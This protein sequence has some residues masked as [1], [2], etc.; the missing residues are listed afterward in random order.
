M[1]TL[2]E[3]LKQ[4][5]PLI[6]KDTDEEIL[7]LY[8]PQYQNAYDD[9]EHFQQAANETNWNMPAPKAR[10]SPEPTPP[11]PKDQNY[12][13]G[14]WNNLGKGA[15]GTA[16]MVAG[17]GEYLSDVTGAD[18][19]KDYF[20][21]RRTV[22]G[23]IAENIA[24]PVESIEEIDGLFSGFE[25]A[26]GQ[27]AQQ[28]LNLILAGSLVPLAGAIVPG[29]AAGAGLVTKLSH[30]AM[31]AAIGSAPA[32][33]VLNTGESYS[34]LENAG[35]ATV[36]GSV[37][38]AL[39]SIGFGLLLGGPMGKV[40]GKSFLKAL[41]ST[42]DS[43]AV[44]KVLTGIA[45]GIASEG[46][47]EGAQEAVDVAAEKYIKDLGITLTDDDIMGILN[48]AASGAA[49]G[50]LLGGFGNF[51][52]HN[53]D[54]TAKEEVD[55]IEKAIKD[56]LAGLSTDV[57]LDEELVAK[58]EEV[59]K[60]EGL[61]TEGVPNGTKAGLGKLAQSVEEQEQIEV[62]PF[63]STEIVSLI[64]GE[65]SEVGPF[66][67]EEIDPLLSDEAPK[68][69][70]GKEKAA[71]IKG[72]TA[73]VEAPKAEAS[74]VE[75]KAEAKVEAP[76]KEAPAPVVVMTN[77]TS[78][79]SLNAQKAWQRTMGKPA[80]ATLTEDQL[81]AFLD[82]VSHKTLNNKN[83][84][85]RKLLGREEWFKN[86]LAGRKETA[87]Q[88]TSQKIAHLITV[89]S[90]SVITPN[91]TDVAIPEDNKDARKDIIKKYLGK[92]PKVLTVK[93]I[94]ELIKK[95]PSEHLASEY[96]WLHEIMADTPYANWYGNLVVQE[97]L[98][99]EVKGN[100]V[101]DT[102]TKID[103]AP[104][105]TSSKKSAFELMTPEEKVEEEK[106][107]RR[108]IIPAL[109][110]GHFINGYNGA[111]APAS[112]L[113]L[114]RRQ[115]VAETGDLEA[116]AKAGNIPYYAWYMGRIHG[117]LKGKQYADEVIDKNARRAA[118]KDSKAV[119]VVNLGGKLLTKDGSAEATLA[120]DGLYDITIEGKPYG[121]RFQ[122]EKA[123][124]DFLEAYAFRQAEL[125]R[126]RRGKAKY[127]ASKNAVEEDSTEIDPA[128]AAQMSNEEAEGTAQADVDDAFL[129][130]VID[131]ERDEVEEGDTDNLAEGG[132]SV[133]GGALHNSYAYQDGQVR[134]PIQN[135]EKWAKVVGEMRAL[136]E[137]ILGSSINRMFF[138]EAPYI[139]WGTHSARGVTTALPNAGHIAIASISKDGRVVV[140][141]ALHLAERLGLVAPGDINILNSSKHQLIAL[142]EEAKK[143]G[144]LFPSTDVTQKSMAEIRAYGLEAYYF[145]KNRGKNPKTLYGKAKEIFSRI[146]N[147]FKNMRNLLAQND[148]RTY[149]DIFDDFLSGKMAAKPNT[150]ATL[151]YFKK[152]RLDAALLPHEVD[153]IGNTV[154]RTADGQPIVFFRR[155]A[156]EGEIVAV[157]QASAMN[158]SM[159][160][161]DLH[162]IDFSIAPAFMNMKN[163]LMI[164]IS[165][166]NPSP[167]TIME[168]LIERSMG[169]TVSYNILLGVEQDMIK[170]P[171]K[172]WKILTDVLKSAGF[173]G[174]QIN[175]VDFLPHWIS[176][177]ENQFVY[178]RVPE[179]IDVPAGLD[180]NFAEVIP[181]EAVPFT[182]A[183]VAQKGQDT[184][185]GT[186][187]KVA[188]KIADPAWI[189]DHYPAFAPI[190]RVAKEMGNKASEIQNKMLPKLRTF[191]ENYASNPWRFSVVG[192]NKKLQLRINKT[193]NLTRAVAAMD[194]FGLTVLEDKISP[195]AL[196]EDM[197]QSLNEDGVSTE[198]FLYRV[199]VKQIQRLYGDFYGEE[200]DIPVNDIFH[201]ESTFY[202][203]YTDWQTVKNIYEV[204]QMSL[205]ELGKARIAEAGKIMGAILDPNTP[206]AVLY[207]LLPDA[208]KID[209]E[210]LDA[211]IKDLEQI[212]KLKGK[213]YIPHMRHGDY[214]IAVH[215]KIVEAD[216]TIKQGE[217][218][219]LEYFDIPILKRDGK[220]LLSKKRRIR[221]T[222]AE[223]MNAMP[224]EYK[225]E[226]RY[227]ISPM[228]PSRDYFKRTPLYKNAL[229][230]LVDIQSL[231][232][233]FGIALPG[234]ENTAEWDTFNMEM[235]HATF[236]SQ[237]KYQFVRRKNIPGYINTSNLDSYLDSSL[238]RGTIR[239][240]YFIA[241]ASTFSKASE[242][243]EN[244]QNNKDVGDYA[245]KYFQ[246]AFTPQEEFAAI[247]QAAFSWAIG[248][249]FAS[250]AV[251]ATQL[252]VASAPF[253]SHF[254]GVRQTIKHM[255]KALGVFRKMVNWQ[256]LKSGQF[257]AFSEDI[258]DWEKK[259]KSIDPALWKAMHAAAQRGLLFPISTDSQR[260][261]RRI[262]GDAFAASNRAREL[263]AEV[264]N[265]AAT[266]FN[267]VEI[268][269]R[270]V[271]FVA[272]YEMAR[273]NP[274][275]RAKMQDYMKNT[276]HASDIAEAKGSAEMLASIAVEKTQFLVDKINRPELMRGVMAIPT[277]FL[278]FTTKMTQLQLEG[279]GEAYKGLK[280]KNF[281]KTKMAT[282][283][284]M[285]MWAL[286]GVFVY[287][288]IRD[289]F[290]LLGL[291]SDAPPEEE[292]RL[293]ANELFGEDLAKLT[294]YGIPTTLG[295]DISQRI[296]IQVLPSGLIEGHTA[297]IGPAA[298]LVSGAITE[299]LRRRGQ[300]YDMAY[301]ASA[302]LPIAMK[303]M[304]NAVDESQGGARSGSGALLGYEPN[305]LETFIKFLG[306][307]PT[308][309]SERRRTVYQ[310][311]AFDQKTRSATE[312]VHDQLTN[313]YWDRLKA[314]RGGDTEE[315]Q[316][317]T[318]D[319][320]EMI[321][322]VREH[323][324][325][326][327]PEYRINLN[328][329]TVQERLRRDLLRSNS[330]PY[331]SGIRS[332][333]RRRFR[334]QYY[335]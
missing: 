310:E 226:D 9:F 328:L 28:T 48:S 308:Q 51:L 327:E 15:Y 320:R 158:E 113:S 150:E 115:E 30:A 220:K 307:T 154:V 145:M 231:A 46:I 219:Y 19:A 112:N 183:Y 236:T 266:G 305:A 277:Q 22:L 244:V 257:F 57:A 47:T 123:A 104:R 160:T 142:V 213:F 335:S 80:P 62:G 139:I 107:S 42:S 111:P 49:V 186:G 326:V 86:Y 135:Q 169:S 250:A 290:T 129:E 259:P 180:T 255:T 2:T 106:A 116:N 69:V 223:H 58:G 149:Q 128:I 287:P 91:A 215:D 23:D 159:P 25:W 191:K 41:M 312:R 192:T 229:G 233:K 184:G 281:S 288:G 268:M 176:F 205:D 163:P 7:N 254:G 324:Q 237:V 60:E 177:D 103:E 90:N 102:A 53:S 202:L 84:F 292:V 38:A 5:N 45:G 249:N 263:W 318:A 311:Q 108:E 40:F 286:G 33:F 120:K 196:S 314:K 283:M 66:T 44:R 126:K 274:S 87:D 189:A 204:S 152:L 208:G 239:N 89:P 235:K 71:I 36:A 193:K 43:K 1:S 20:N 78:G 100:Q 252:A 79:L 105:I 212:N 303:N 125:A 264:Q 267:F 4:G 72:N 322:D 124:N 83:H 109:I 293:W 190:F 170:N 207:G 61:S 276:H 59:L 200:L 256:A 330:D 76:K 134:V 94:Q 50:G 253:L 65:D 77:F 144:A 289:L 136:A 306:F 269:N 198:N 70:K 304:A 313:L 216:G 93:D 211:L 166:W 181:T 147:F 301:S 241:R 251:N 174:L 13:E 156:D 224:D 240:A 24:V 282:M 332:D 245:L 197:R 260:S 98:T 95:L 141:E 291:M 272:A 143:L 137:K 209:S 39:D 10:V 131:S 34:R 243:L 234:A 17:F 302:L 151:E 68:T 119:S 218:R 331:L 323:N 92:L 299:F 300:G 171:A 262:G 162:L 285:T 32:S 11:D 201:A 238:L 132:T 271:T 185:E 101:S 148:I 99:R 82:K 225:N 179:F 164:N 261:S 325:S 133:E 117:A 294:L 85:L 8:W 199:S 130:S 317:I 63:T 278:S 309:Q 146:W 165:E 298:G 319:I 188:R 52:Q 214:A 333:L 12:F 210:K 296:G 54:R 121:R 173:D 88:E 172:A 16:S 228:S 329:E 138:T 114:V 6:A 206:L 55:Q 167:L 242:A 27:L 334:Q 187:F 182:E 67:T 178:T 157:S 280:E 258:I 232:H 155:K 275:F 127:L 279:L 75:A 3:L 315:V 273:T 161:S 195:T 316:S 284:A 110:K 297:E 21:K 140:H 221:Q 97:R 175:P 56:T 247:R 14:L 96:Y 194:H 73:K 222:T 74:K 29:V 81:V 26:T 217:I 246:Y 35:A 295:M 265:F 321:A 122:T 18:D 118:K 248:F 227:I 31:T 153:A 230:E 37:K 203:D 64:A 168:A 270:V